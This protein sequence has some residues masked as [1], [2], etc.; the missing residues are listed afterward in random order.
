MDPEGQRRS[1]G[2]GREQQGTSGTSSRLLLGLKMFES[3]DKHCRD[4]LSFIIKQ[5][6]YGNINVQ[7]RDYEKKALKRLK[8]A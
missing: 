3:S 8:F 1:R 6:K 4:T 2:K 5:G 7:T